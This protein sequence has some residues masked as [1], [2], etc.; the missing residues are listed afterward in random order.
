MI[1]FVSRH[2]HARSDRERSGSL[3]S[4]PVVGLSL[5]ASILVCGLILLVGYDPLAADVKYDWLVT[6]EA[7]RA[8]GDAYGDLLA[9]A[10][11]EGVSVQI[12]APPGTDAVT[13]HPRT[14]GALLIQAPIALLPYELLF[15]LGAGATTLAVGLIA[16]FTPIRSRSRGV[17]YLALVLALAP[18]FIAIRFAGQ[19]GLVAVLALLGWLLATR[20]DSRLAGVMIGVAG[21]LKVFPMFLLIPL[22]LAGRKSSAR[23]LVGTF[24]GLNLA[25]LLLPGVSFA[26]ALEAITDA[27][28]TWLTLGSNA[29]VVRHLADLGVSV[30]AAQ[31]ITLASALGFVWLLRR[32]VSSWTSP[33]VW[34]ALGLLVTP[35]S[36]ISYGIVLYPAVIMMLD[37]PDPD[38]RYVGWLAVG[39]SVIPVL[40]YPVAIVSMGSTELAV[41]VLVVIVCLWKPGVFAPWSIG[42]P[43][44]SAARGSGVLAGPRSAQVG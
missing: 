10:N 21:V 37:G 7:M 38:V 23:W 26:N 44:R 14:P 12:N 43:N 36:W 35:L 17:G 13:G 5:A 22:L 30:P 18:T 42:S 25:G 31:V 11:A 3:V 15:A 41:R 28:G 19:A 1:D 29:S 32:R 8:G 24:A 6:R 16:A 20:S 4:R 27:T 33:F 9:M 39:L 40:A 2:R 34:I